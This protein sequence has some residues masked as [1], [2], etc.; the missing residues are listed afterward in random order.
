GASGVPAGHRGRAGRTGPPGPDQPTTRG[1]EVDM[2][3]LTLYQPWASLVV[4]GEKKIETRSW[5]TRHVG[6]LAIHASATW[7]PGFHDICD[8]PAFRKALEHL[9]LL[10]SRL[11]LGAVLGTA[12]LIACL[13]T[14]RLLEEGL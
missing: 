5:S 3:A 4:L 7:P 11:P 1:R 13:P 12:D 9:G 8:S 14:E 6:P 10:A 2:R